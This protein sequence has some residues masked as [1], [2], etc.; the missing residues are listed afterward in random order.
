VCKLVLDGEFSVK[1]FQ[2]QVKIC[3]LHR[4]TLDID[5]LCITLNNTVTIPLKHGCFMRTRMEGI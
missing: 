2:N 5:F 3:I 4:N 1:K